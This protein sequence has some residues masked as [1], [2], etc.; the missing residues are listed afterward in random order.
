MSVNP[1]KALPRGESLSYCCSWASQNFVAK[2]R[3][4]GK[5]AAAEDFFGALGSKLARAEL[6]EELIFGKGGFAEQFPEVRKDLFFVLDDGW[7]VPYSIDPDCEIHMFGSLEIDTERFPSLQGT[8]AERLKQMNEMLRARGWR[9]LGLWIAPQVQGESYDDPDLDYPKHEAYWRERI[10]WCKHA[11]VRYWKVD[12]G[13]HSGKVEYRKMMT[14]LGHE[15]FPELTIEH[16]CCLIPVN[17]SPLEGLIRYE[18]F[19]KLERICKICAYSDAFRSYDVTDDMLSA[20][21]TLDRLSTLLEVSKGIVNCEDEL[22]MGAALGC[23]VGIMRSAYGSNLYHM[24]TRLD[25][26]TAAIRWQRIAPPFAGG[27]LLRSEW[28]LTDRCYFRPEDTWFKDI[29]GKTV[30]QAAP[31]V[32]ARN[33]PLPTVEGDETVP[34]VIAS[35]NP[36]GAYS[37]AAIRRRIAFDRTTP[38][39]VTC[40]A[41][42]SEQIG[43]FGSFASVTLR[44]DRPVKTV[45]A[46]SLIRGDA[47]K[48]PV[49]EIVRGNEVCL[50]GA[51]LAQFDT[52]CDN[53][54]NAVMLT[55]SFADQN[56]TGMEQ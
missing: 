20:T 38:P 54:E 45:V 2:N 32:I 43:V 34:F 9:G 27:P 25:E 55:V 7:D 33:T 29:H 31:A 21:T 47:R 17:G 4:L 22:Y 18:N 1:I 50:S 48:L 36:S 3:A 42:I 26:A 40:F 37:L 15:L 46:Q 44:F 53:S 10:L 41:G 24:C 8:P 12:W 14:D 51:L 19:A 23:A 49:E 6:N 5:G 39:C 52:T 28:I 30:E 16:A 56:G 13:K 11:D 35:Q